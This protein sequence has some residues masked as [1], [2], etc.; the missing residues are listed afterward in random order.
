MKDNNLYANI[1]RVR[2]LRKDN[3]NKGIKNGR[4]SVSK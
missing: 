4:V 3:I 2:E 1:K